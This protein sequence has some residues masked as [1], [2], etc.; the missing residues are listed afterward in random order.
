MRLALKMGYERLEWALIAAAAPD[1]YADDSWRHNDPPPVPQMSV[2]EVLQLLFLHE[3]SVRQG[4]EKP[5]RRKHRAE[6]WK[7]YTER[8]RAMWTAE[9][10]REA[11][12]A[13]LRRAAQYETSGDWRFEHEK[14]LPE[15]GRGSASGGGG[16]PLL[17]ALEQVTGW[18]KAKGNPPH[19]AG[20]AL[21]G[22]WRLEDWKKREREN[23]K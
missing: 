17:P 13:A 6:P 9:K 21:F 18:S 22:G 14:I 23:R 20:L 1:A 7:T 10:A 16:V 15:T 3:K 8:L 12:D 19:K 5:H 11:E 4:W 2:S